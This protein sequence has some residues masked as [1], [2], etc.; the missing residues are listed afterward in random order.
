MI[1]KQ[2]EKLINLRNAY[3]VVFSLPEGQEILDDMIQKYLMKDP[4]V[5][6][7]PQATMVNLGMQR[8]AIAMLKKVYKSPQDIRMAI[9]R[10]FQHAETE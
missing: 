9:E 1:P 6:D 3:K 4:V 10:S 2:T 7:D 8:L 5:V